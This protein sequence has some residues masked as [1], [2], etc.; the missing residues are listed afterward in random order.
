M[1]PA[2][3][4]LRGPARILGVA[5]AGVRD[6]LTRSR[7]AGFWALCMVY[8]VRFTFTLASNTAPPVPWLEYLTTSFLRTQWRFAPMFLLV[9]AVDRLASRK[10]RPRI[11]ALAAAV[12]VGAAIGW[13][14]EWA[15]GH[16]LPEDTVPDQDAGTVDFVNLVFV[17]LNFTYLGLLGLAVYLFAERNALAIASRQ[18]EEAD[19]VELDRQ[20]AEARLHV[21]Q[22]Q[23]EP[24]FLFNT[25][26][27]VRLL[28]QNDPVRG[29]EMLRSLSR[30]LAGALP[31][32]RDAATTLGQEVDL[33][34][35][36][37]AV[38]KIRM[39]SR[40]SFAIEVPPSLRSFPM[41]PMMLATLAEN[42]VKHGLAPLPEGGHLRIIAQAENGRLRLIVADSGAGFHASVGTGVGLANVRARTRAVFG[43]SARFTLAQNLPRGITATLDLPMGP[44]HAV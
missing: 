25:L 9:L 1:D 42:A 11:A 4:A 41:P 40:L 32:M 20:F 21:M 7:L 10:L 36:Y 3:N 33:V 18:T 13:F 5:W 16:A 8:A 44:A 26:A 28:Y 30:Y 22:A 27:T 15:I 23:I 31:R 34:E 38:Q 39:A 17:F 29:R 24:H 14:D 2:R 43:E 19:R 35:A 12:V 6:G 37:L